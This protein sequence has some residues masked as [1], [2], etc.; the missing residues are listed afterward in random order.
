MNEPSN[1]CA[2]GD[3]TLPKATAHKIGRNKGNH[4]ETHNL[5]GLLMTKAG[6]EGIQKSKPSSRPWIFSRS[7]WAG[8]PD[9]PTWATAGSFAGMMGCLKIKSFTL[10]SVAP[11]LIV[12]FKTKRYVVFINPV[13]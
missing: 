9:G 10:S 5:Y 12:S 13:I 8:F 11:G 7:G 1:F 4:L 3:L 2:W 6:Y